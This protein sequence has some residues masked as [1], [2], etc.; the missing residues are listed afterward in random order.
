MSWPPHVAELTADEAR[1]LALAAQGMVGAPDRRSGVAGLVRSLGAVQLD[2]ISVLARSHE[3][4]AYAR[5]GAVPRPKVEAA[6]WGGGCFEYWAHAACILPQTEWPLLAFR[7][8]RFT[9][10]YRHDRERLATVCDEIL[11]RIKTEG[12][13]T[14]TAL[15]GARKSTYW[16]DWS[17]VKLA[18]ECLIDTGTLICASRIGWRRVYDLPERVLPSSVSHDDLDD[19]A[20]LLELLRTAA[21][22][23]GVATAADLADYFRLARADVVR[24]LPDSG[25]A[26]VSVAGWATSAWADP[27]ALA[28]GLPR[29]RHRTTLLSPFDSLVWDRKRTAR[30]FGLDH[31]LE[32]YVPKPARQHGYYAMPVLTGGRLVARVDPARADGALVARQITIMPEAATP[33]RLPATAVAIAIALA[34]AATWVGC[35]AVAIET[36][37][38]ISAAPAVK[39]AIG[40]LTG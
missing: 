28:R 18:A 31:R 21:R 32:A 1:R 24:L 20:C 4:V 25:L 6:Y 19:D 5:L 16:W 15:G 26:S 10:R 9:Q 14:V 40:K 13:M 17:D 7:R 2:T 8:R 37:L 35:A 38:P 36:V 39:S 29:G 34:E 11:H 22:A 3:L 27:A 33:A 23:L 12:P 30:I